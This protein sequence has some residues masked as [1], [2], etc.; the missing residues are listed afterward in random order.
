M[1]GKGPLVRHLFPPSPLL[2]NFTHCLWLIILCI[3]PSSL[4]L[5][6]HSEHRFLF[7]LL[8]FPTGHTQHCVSCVG[9]RLSDFLLLHL[10]AQPLTIV[11]WTVLLCFVNPM[12]LLRLKVQS[13]GREL[14]TRVKAA[15]SLGKKRMARK[16]T[17]TEV[18]GRCQG[19]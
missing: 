9:R 7:L 2:V 3:G 4:V 12:N 10:S 17:V 15:I 8:V 18:E 11:N 1:V 14:W 13:T 16:G 5:Y 19:K 6:R